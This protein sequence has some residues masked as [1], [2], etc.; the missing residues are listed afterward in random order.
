MPESP[1]TWVTHVAE[2]PAAWRVRCCR[3]EVQSGPDQGLARDH[4][5]ARIRVGARKGLELT[6]TDPKVS[7]LHFELG[8]EDHGC[9]LRDLESTNGTF[10]AGLRV[11]DVYLE[12]NA[13]IRIGD[14]RISFHML[15]TSIEVPLSEHD[16]FGSL[17]GRSVAMRELFA[18][19]ERIAGSSATVL[20]TGETGTGK[21]LVAE[22]L[23]ERSP[24]A[25][26][27]L[28]VV[29]CSA[30]PAT[31][32]ESELFGYERGAFTGATVAHPGAFERADSGTLFLDE[33]G[34]LPL[35]LQPKL[36]RALE[37][38]QVRRIG[39]TRTVA[40]DMR[41]IAATNRDLQAEVEHG[42]FREDLYYRLAVACVHVPPLRQ[43]KEDVPLLIEHFLRS[44]PGGSAHRPTAATIARL[45][46]LSWP[47]N[48]RELRN[49]V[50]RLVLM[51]ETVEELVRSL[52]DGTRGQ[53]SDAAPRLESPIDINIPFKLAKQQ[54]IDEFDRKYIELLLAQH[55]GNVSAAG[56]A[57]G[58]DRMSI[59]KILNRL[60]A[61]R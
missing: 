37:S 50:E 36:L 55:D 12:S 49:T 13:V 53:A 30:I 48:V 3:L 1:P 43:R 17:V 34:E 38:R 8:L 18:R 5:C 39:S 61:R 14:T 7:A 10:V 29:D 54:V 33:V 2:R 20:V 24:R 19:L 26:G 45:Q 40:T 47:G 44:L 42:R 23:H 56:R 28:V 35:E 52:R 11:N 51:P 31:L 25:R 22:A 46:Q 9:R 57:A 58:I 41:V 27:P 15:G 16:Q 4:E 21:E 6:L 60:Q 32:I 59:H